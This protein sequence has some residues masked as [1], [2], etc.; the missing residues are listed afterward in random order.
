MNEV[1]TYKKYVSSKYDGVNGFY[2]MKELRDVHSQDQIEDFFNKN[3]NSEEEV[4]DP[5]ILL[6]ALQRLLNFGDQSQQ[7]SAMDMI[8]E[9][10]RENPIKS[11]CVL[12]E[13]NYFGIAKEFLETQNAKYFNYLIP[14]LTALIEACESEEIFEA[15]PEPIIDIVLKYISIDGDLQLTFNILLLIQNLLISAPKIAELLIS[16]N[17]FVILLSL[18][19]QVSQIVI[20]NIEADETQDFH[21]SSFS[22]SNIGAICFEIFAEF[23]SNDI[24][25]IPIDLIT[26]LLEKTGIFL[27]QKYYFGIISASL[28]CLLMIIQDQNGYEYFIQANQK[29]QI[30]DSICMA[31]R[32]AEEQIISMGL[33]VIYYLSLCQI[34]LPL[35]KLFD[36]FC[37]Y[38]DVL[39][40]ELF[41]KFLSCL[42][43]LAFNL[44]IIPYFDGNIIEKLYQMLGTAKL[45]LRG[46]IIQIFARLVLW[47]IA[48]WL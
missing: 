1:S 48:L 46:K 15:F 17:V 11:K 5:N 24:Q 3:S 29:F 22:F 6:A 45:E 38:L 34:D 47:E 39:K 21:R 23:I 8:K 32:L 27:K 18:E 40:G 43:E 7:I 10:I 20:L 26:N 30:I 13:R 9:L 14:T 36:I 12:L 19:Q 33:D 28:Y 37:I 42:S 2:R 16:H 31:L 4:Y 25:I 44:N 35:L 41:T